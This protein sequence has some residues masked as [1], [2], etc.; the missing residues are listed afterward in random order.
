MPEIVVGLLV[1]VYIGASNDWP[2]ADTLFLG[3]VVALLAYFGSCAVLPY[4]R[5]PNPWCSKCR[6]TTGDRRGHYRRRRICPICHGE[7]WR[8]LGS[9]VIGRG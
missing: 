4:R 6:P 5:C 3:G 1:G 8:R 2:A 7:D 9:R